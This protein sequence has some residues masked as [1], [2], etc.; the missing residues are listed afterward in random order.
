LVVAHDP[1]HLV[2][3]QYAEVMRSILAARAVPLLLWFLGAT[4]KCGTTTVVLNLALTAAQSGTVPVTVVEAGPRHALPQRV[5]LPSGPAGP[6]FQDKS[7]QLRFVS[8]AG[9]E[10][11]SLATILENEPEGLILVDGPNLEEMP[12]DVSA[13]AEAC[14]AVYVVASNEDRPPVEG[15]GRP[16]DGWIIAQ[17]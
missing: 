17:G 11:H 7:N 14:H 15:L 6:F 9:R 8:G 10:G 13:M 16:V 5:G 4:P 3:R 1:H 12:E 2:S